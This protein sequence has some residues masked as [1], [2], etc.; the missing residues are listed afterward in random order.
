[1]SERI[2]LPVVVDNDGNASV[3]AE[4]RSAPRAAPIMW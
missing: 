1:M 4:A 2:G 3:L